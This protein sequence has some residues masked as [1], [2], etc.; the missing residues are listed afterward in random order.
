MDG[1]IENVPTY[2]SIA[3]HAQQTKIYSS[4]LFYMKI[5]VKKILTKRKTK[6]I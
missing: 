6:K 3:L 1:N 4:I 5:A 2:T